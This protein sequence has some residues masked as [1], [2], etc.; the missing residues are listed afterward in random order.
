MKANND[1][2][3]GKRKVDRVLSML[4]DGKP[5]LIIYSTCTNL[6]RT[7]PVL[8]YDPIMVEDVDSEAEDHA[9]D[10]LRY[11]LTNYRMEGEQQKERK[12][13]PLARYDRRF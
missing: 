8:P 12:E 9:Y 6:L 13:N 7:L 4:P 10:A 5:G 3:G 1:R 2:L 11:G